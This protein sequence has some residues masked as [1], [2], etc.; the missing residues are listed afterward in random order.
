MK[1]QSS[2]KS[3][4]SFGGQEYGLLVLTAIELFSFSVY[5]S[6]GGFTTDICSVFVVRISNKNLS[7]GDA[8]PD[9]RDGSP[10]GRDGSPDDDGEEDRL[11]SVSFL[12]SSV[13]VGRI[14]C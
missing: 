5:Y 6:Q 10:G 4:Y 9:G 3:P 13:E 2:T 11:T 1:P 7:G 8:F 14:C 12:K